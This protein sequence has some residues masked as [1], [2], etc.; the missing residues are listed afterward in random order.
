MADGPKLGSH[1]DRK[2]L[3]SSVVVHVY[4]WSEE[5][6]AAIGYG[7]TTTSCTSEFSD[8]AELSGLRQQYE[9]VCFGFTLTLLSVL[10]PIVAAFCRFLPPKMDCNSME[11]VVMGDMYRYRNDTS[12]LKHV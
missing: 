1:Q 12:K 5:S 10:L 3:A 8:N 2:R 6:K 11:R 7:K 9:V 4:V